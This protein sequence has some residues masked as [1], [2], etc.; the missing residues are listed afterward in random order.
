MI[1]KMPFDYDCP[2]N[3]TSNSMQALKSFYVIV[4]IQA[5]EKMHL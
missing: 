2:R 3:N 1:L 5:L 4:I